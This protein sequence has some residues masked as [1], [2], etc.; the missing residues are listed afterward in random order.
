MKLISLF[1]SVLIIQLSYSQDYWETVPSFIASPRS[2][3]ASFSIASKGYIVGGLDQVDF[4]RK[5]YSFSAQTN[6]WQEELA[7]GDSTGAGLN[8]GGACGFSINNKGYVC[9][10]QGQ[11]NAFFNDLWEFNPVTQAWTQKANFI[12]SARREA[13]SFVLD[14]I[15]YIA[16]GED[17]TGYKSDVYAY[18][19]FTNSWNQKNDF[20][21]GA[22][23]SA[24]GFTIGDHAFIGT[25][26]S[27][28]LKN[29]FWMYLAVNDTWIQKSYF[30]GTPRSGAVAWGKFPQ[31]YIACGE[32]NS[33][34]YKN[35]VWEYNY[36]GNAWFLRSSIP[37]NGRK[38]AMVFTIDEIAYVGGG[39]N[40]GFLNDYYRYIGVVGID[41]ENQLSVLP[42]PN[43]STTGFNFNLTTPIQNGTLKIYDIQGKEVLSKD[44]TNEQLIYVSFE[45][46]AIDKGIY[47]YKISS[48]QQ[49]IACGKLHYLYY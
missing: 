20:L 24:V 18:N 30:P 28:V 41:E 39:F 45:N 22:R 19:P 13:V 44:F 25:G 31:G 26:E 46:L 15:A 16:T 49:Q 7:L 42:Y 37:G 11:T 17:I 5:S 35:D 23:K 6:A 4:K 36:F 21:G 47:C 10:G 8:R 3:S 2:N 1:I 29:D 9:L 48:N 12:G 40:G 32:D 43:P 14:S 34:T 27:N 38:N 33:F